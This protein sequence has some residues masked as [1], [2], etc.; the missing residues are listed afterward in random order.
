MDLKGLILLSSA[1]NFQTI[2]P[3]NEN[4]L[5]YLLNL[6][7]YT[8]VAWYHH[9][10]APD[11]QKDLDKTLADVQRWAVQEYG[12][13]LTEGDELPD[14]QRRK[15]IATLHRFT[16]LPEAYIDRCNLRI[17]A[18]RFAA[19]LLRD[20]RR[21]VGI[22]DG[23]VTGFPVDPSDASSRYDPSL[24]LVSGPFASA[25]QDYLRRDL[26]FRTDQPYVYLSHKAN[27][28]WDWGSAAEGYVDVTD[29]LL[30]AMTEQADLRVFGGMGYF[31]LT[32]GYFGQRYAFNHL[33]LA[34]QLGANLHLVCYPSGHQI[35]TQD[36]SRK[37]LASDVAE[38][39]RAAG[40]G[41]T[42]PAR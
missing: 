40:T 37:K 21:V 18:G 14:A 26:E 20:E 16:S 4:D 10:L 12:P 29:D 5:P 33:G 15:V 1:L 22:L 41:S 25:L 27:E 8:A 19:E 3:A 35:Y 42:A 39:V 36:A 13:A 34:P 23:R 31:D 38:F 30:R 11:L 6:P 2:T 24:V 7:S 17:P 32:T 28:S 9:K